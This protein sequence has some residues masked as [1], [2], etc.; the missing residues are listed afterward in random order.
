MIPFLNDRLFQYQRVQLN[1]DVYLSNFEAK[2]YQRLAKEIDPQ[3]YFTIYGCND[4]IKTLIK[5]VFENYGKDKNKANRQTE[6]NTDTT[7]NDGAVHE[8]Q[9]EN[10][11]QPNNI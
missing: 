4:C 9:N 2:E 8:V 7:G 1:I 3:R 11:E 6:K 5:F 10:K